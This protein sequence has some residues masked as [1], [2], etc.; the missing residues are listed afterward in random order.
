MNR[1]TYDKEVLTL[2]DL[3]ASANKKLDKATAGK[4]TFPVPCTPVLTISSPRI[5]RRWSHGSR[6]VCICGWAV[7]E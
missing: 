6:D 3:E 5:L 7:G 2:S 4:F 1:D